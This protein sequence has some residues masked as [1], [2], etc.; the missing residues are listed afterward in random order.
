M[1]SLKARTAKLHKHAS[2]VLRPSSKREQLGPT[3]SLNTRR[4]SILQ[5]SKVS[6]ILSSLRFSSISRLLPSK[7]VPSYIGCC[8]A[9][10]VNP[11]IIRVSKLNFHSADETI[12]TD[13]GTSMDSGII[14]E[15]LCTNR[16]AADM[17]RHV[18]E[19]PPPDRTV[20]IATQATLTLTDFTEICH[21]DSA[22][23]LVDSTAARA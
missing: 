20:S 12:F 21:V 13:N 3:P 15:T 8:H 22:A 23:G 5:V 2:S 6:P 17:H 19:S 1:V 9:S 4:Q 10:D 7:D 14:P 16:T 11:R 18:H